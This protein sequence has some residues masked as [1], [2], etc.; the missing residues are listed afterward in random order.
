MSQIF[1]VSTP[2]LEGDYRKQT[3][4][5]SLDV[6]SLQAYVAAVVYTSKLV[7]SE[8]GPFRAERSASFCNQDGRT[9]ICNF[10]GFDVPLSP[11]FA[12]PEDPPSPIAAVTGDANDQLIGL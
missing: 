4:E 8:Q 6:V 12:I 11:R 5:A 1:R 7:C 3:L 2:A 9:H 10:H